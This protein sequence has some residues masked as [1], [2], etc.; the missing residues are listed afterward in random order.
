MKII[1]EAK[2]KITKF[3]EKVKEDNLRKKVQKEERKRIKEAEREE[4]RKKEEAERIE[5]ERK[6]AEEKKNKLIKRVNDIKALAAELNVSPEFLVLL[7]MQEKLGDEID[8]IKSSI[9]YVET[10]VMS[11]SSEID[12]IKNMKGENY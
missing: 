12:E 11:V 5:R 2:E 9:D 8:N 10:C 3:K 6:E 1:D 4:R 7:E